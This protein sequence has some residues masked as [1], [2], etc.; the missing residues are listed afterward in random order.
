MLV[1]TFFT[2][3]LAFV[4]GVTTLLSHLS[5]TAAN[6]KQTNLLFLMCDDL[7]PE[8]SNYGRSF[9]QTPNFERL[10]QKSVT[11][12]YAFTS[13]AVC[14]PSRDSLMTGLRPDTNGNYNFQRSW[15]PHLAFPQQLIRS[16]YNTAQVG[17]IFHWDGN[18]KA[19]W[20]FDAFDNGWYDYQNK[21]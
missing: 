18:N 7:R 10:A 8:M 9:M 1:V 15:S 20:S 19:V 16:G 14:N 2:T 12:D 3:H 5:H 4:L 13:V 21:E 6:I 17:K 11:F